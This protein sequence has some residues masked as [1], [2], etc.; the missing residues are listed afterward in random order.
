MNETNEAAVRAGAK[1]EE[2][3][4]L[5]AILVSLRDQFRE[6][7]VPE[8]ASTA[9]EM[10]A[11]YD[12]YLEFGRFFRPQPLPRG[13]RRGEP[14][15]CYGNAYD[16][17]VRTAGLTYCE[18]YALISTG[19]SAA[20]VEHGWC[21]TADG[22]VVEVTL[23]QPGLSYFGVAYRP[24]QLAGN[25]DLPLVDDIVLARLKGSPAGA[26]PPVAE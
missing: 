26:P 19:S 21:V 22:Q 6:L 11:L 5:F 8:G 17:A 23:R 13:F 18:G 14:N 4:A 2:D 1:T 3:F 24:E 9:A 16:L 12:H 20:E 10:V 25:P 7:T 15:Q